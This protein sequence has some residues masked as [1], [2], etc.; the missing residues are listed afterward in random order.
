MP[1]AYKSVA[2][3]AVASLLA[4]TSF[5]GPAPPQPQVI[6]GTLRKVD[7]GTLTVQTLK[8][9]ETVIL[10]ANTRIHRAAATISAANLRWF[11]GQRIKVRYF[12]QRGEKRAQSITIARAEK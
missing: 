6:L 2:A 9:P 7:D 5:A 1:G 4:A 8:G 3:A 12:D 11:I 10:A